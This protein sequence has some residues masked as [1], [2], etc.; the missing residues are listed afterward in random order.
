[1]RQEGAGRP[2]RFFGLFL[3]LWVAGRLASLSGHG[4]PPDRIVAA[5]APVRPTL[6]IAIPETLPRPSRTAFFVWKQPPILRSRRLAPFLL[7]SP[8]QIS[9]AAAQDEGLPVDL[10]NFIAFSVA[11]ANRHYASD[12]GMSAAPP[13][14]PPPEFPGSVGKTRPDRWAASA[15]LLR[16]GGSLSVPGAVPAG[17]LGGSQAGIRID[18]GL[19]PSAALRP[20]AYARVTSALDSPT[21]PEGAVGLSLQ[22]VRALPIRFALERRVALGKGGRNATTFMAVGGFGPRPVA[23]G[24]EAE[25]YAQAGMVGLQRRDF[26]VDGKLSLLAPVAAS[27]LRIGA[28]M[29]GGAQPGAERLDLG[30]EVQLRLPLP[31]AHARLSLEWRERIAGRAAP[32]SGLALTLAS[33]F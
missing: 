17:R 30:P 22:P 16:R 27:P 11:F 32:S 28:S 21:A 9:L 18:Y 20:T 26:F 19:A 12:M 13:A 24:L 25:G 15:W 5:A 31:H 6:A 1:M 33:D 2:V 4:V 29:S 10:M 7:P 8:T 3:A 14:T 23:G